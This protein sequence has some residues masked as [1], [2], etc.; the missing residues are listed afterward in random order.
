MKKVIRV[1]MALA[2]VLIMAGCSN[3]KQANS[4]TESNTASSSSAKK[5]Q[6]KRQPQ[7]LTG[8]SHLKTKLTRRLLTKTGGI[9]VSQLKNNGCT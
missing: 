2:L 4:K 6:P 3:G 8:A 9:C 1:C 7:L 5:V